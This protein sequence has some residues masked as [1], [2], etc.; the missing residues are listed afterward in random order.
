MS[1]ADG[2]LTDS[3][4]ARLIS[5]YPLIGFKQTSESGLASDTP[6]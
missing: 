4:R 5:E 1:K 6:F 2:P 3:E